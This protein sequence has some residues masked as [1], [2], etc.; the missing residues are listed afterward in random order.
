V[1]SGESARVT[2]QVTEHFLL[3]TNNYSLC[4]RHV[5]DGQLQVFT[6]SPP[7]ESG[8]VF[9]SYAPVHSLKELKDA[10]GIA[11]DCIVDR[12]E[13]RLRKTG[14]G[15]D[16]PLAS[17]SFSSLSGRSTPSHSSGASDSSNVFPPYIKASS[18]PS[19][20]S[21]TPISLEDLLEFY[22]SG[23]AEARLAWLIMTQGI[24][25]KG[26]LTKAEFLHSCG[27]IFYNYNSLRARLTTPK[28]VSA[29]VS[30][31][32]GVFFWFIMFLTALS[33]FN[34]DFSSIL[35]PLLTIT[36]SLSFALGPLIQRFL[37][38]IIFTLVYAPFEPGDIVSLDGGSTLHVVNV[39]LLSSEF[40]NV[41]TNQLICK[42]NNELFSQT[43]A[44]LSRSG[45]ATLIVPFAL[46]HRVTTGQLDKITSHIKSYLKMLTNEWHEDFSLSALHTSDSGLKNGVSF[47]LSVNS[48]HNWG[49]TR[50]ICK[51][52][53][54]ITLFLVSTLRSMGLEYHVDGLWAKQP[55]EFVPNTSELEEVLKG[56]GVTQD[57][58]ARM[59]STGKFHHSR[60][61]AFHLDL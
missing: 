23:A 17:P 44:N 46:D 25:D 31:V 27:V 4:S 26:L 32:A 2:S 60:A 35:V 15:G 43:I 37:D 52:H 34:V 20:T 11:F 55:P 61:A 45:N 9:V 22:P 6:A 36:V 19:T 42:R 58:E 18:H 3:S 57:S 56:T 40:R 21:I 39:N 30:A 1:Q 5:R 14:V 49:S 8:G 50:K 38:A 24:T 51:A 33:V 54:D 29:A 16:V 12:R 53:T 48:R 7:G 59:R 13:A 10:M 47:S 41:A 28:D